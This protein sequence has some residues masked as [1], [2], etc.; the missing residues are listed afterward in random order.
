MQPELMH[1]LDLMPSMQ[2]AANKRRSEPCERARFAVLSL[3]AH[4]THH[5]AL[6]GKGSCPRDEL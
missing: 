4:G 2:H 6:P 1:S 3:L 5:S